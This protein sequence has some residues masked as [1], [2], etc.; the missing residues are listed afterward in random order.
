[1]AYADEVLADNPTY[2]WRLQGAPAG[3]SLNS[4]TSREVLGVAGDL[5]GNWRGIC[6]DGYAVYVGAVSAGRLRDTNV[7]LYVPTPGSLEIWAWAARRPTAVESIADNAGTNLGESLQ[8][9]TNGSWQGNVGSG[10]AFVAPTSAVVAEQ[11][12]KHLV[13]V[14]TGTRAQLYLNGAIAQDLAGIG[15][16]TSPG[17][18]LSMGSTNAAGSSFQGFLA[19]PAIYGSALSAARVLAHYNAANLKAFDP[20]YLLALTQSSITTIDATTT[21]ILTDSVAILGA[22]QKTYS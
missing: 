19:E 6:T 16:N 10:A 8:H 3:A 14:S 1:M 22:V 2:W 21:T 7:R 15:S 9:N 5:F 13:L 12:W 20:A 18:G 17:Q 4:G 11:A